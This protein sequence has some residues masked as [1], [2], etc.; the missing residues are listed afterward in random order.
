MVA[1]DAN[2]LLRALVGD[3]NS[4]TQKAAAILAAA[5]PRSLLV[6]RLILAECSYVLRSYYK[7]EKVDISDWLH[8]VLADKRFHIPDHEV[9]GLAVTLFA[10]EK[11][12][13][14]EDCWLL[15]LYK[16]D[17]VTDVAS[18]DTALARRVK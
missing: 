4:L 9:L 10:T 13:S 14:F 1:L 18:F 15:A 17:D 12:L 3:D 7:Y 11:P 8:A 6:D 16:R 2:I 5:K